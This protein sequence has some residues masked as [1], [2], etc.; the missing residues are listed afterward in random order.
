MVNF[1]LC[2]FYHLKKKDGGGEIPTS[3]MEL[4]QRKMLVKQYIIS[5]SPLLK[6]QGLSLNP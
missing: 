5:K 4:V 3:K 1:I 6:K 2:I